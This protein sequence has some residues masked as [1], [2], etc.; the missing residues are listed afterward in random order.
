M[1][2]RVEPQGLHYYCRKS[3]THILLDEVKTKPSAY[4]IA[5]RTVSVAITDECDFTCSYCY[6]NLK[7][8]YLKKEDIIS[9]CKQLDKF[10]TFDIAFGGGEPTLHPDLIEICETI[11]KETKLGISITTHGHNLSE[12]FISK[13]KDNLSFIRV[14]IDGIEP[15]YSQLRKKPLD[16]LLP[17]LKL[18]S[19]QI[20]FGINAVI[21]KLTVNHLDNLKTLFLEYG[22]FELLLL[23]MWH[24]GKY[25]L[26][27]NEWS[28][29]KQWIEKNHKEIPIR[30][31]SESK[32]YLKLPFL[33]DTD[34]WDNDYGFIGID[35]T[36]RKNS[37][38]KDGLSIDQY[39]TFE[40]LLTDW[41]N[42]ISTLN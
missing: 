17:K 1:K 28:T 27:D 16:N 13:L 38:T 7:D 39:D 40:L 22:A 31:S 36:L 12:D 14:S 42:T 25:V 4:S 23:P 10:G 2:A 15:I 8:R 11:W 20:P 18:L 26:T 30:I 41:R 3:G 19:G 6:V 24:K 35:K 37:F 21:N 34:E 33:F 29:L 5:P 9:Y 32:K